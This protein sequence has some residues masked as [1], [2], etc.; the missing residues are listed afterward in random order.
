VLADAV[1][2]V[3]QDGLQGRHRGWPRSQR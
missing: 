2:A 1:R 3:E